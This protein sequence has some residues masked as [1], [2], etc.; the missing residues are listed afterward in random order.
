MI[1]IFFSHEMNIN[2]TYRNNSTIFFGEICL[3]I[4]SPSAGT[5]LVHCVC[6]AFSASSLAPSIPCSFP[7]PSPYKLSWRLKKSIFLSAPPL[8]ISWHPLPTIF[9]GTPSH[10][11]FLEPPSLKLCWRP[12]PQPF[13]G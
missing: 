6:R 5:I 10:Q 12:L 2:K 1:I 3:I 11:P 4:D 9:H 8:R 7:A 13:R